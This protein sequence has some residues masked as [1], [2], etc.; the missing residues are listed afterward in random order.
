MDKT[1]YKHLRIVLKDLKER[2]PKTNKDGF[3]A[4]QKVYDAIKALDQ[5]L[6]NNKQTT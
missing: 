5:A 2:I 4:D 3:L 1:L 6:T